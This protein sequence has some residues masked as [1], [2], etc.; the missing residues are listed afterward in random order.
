[1]ADWR[2]TE[3]LKPIDKANFG[4]VSESPGRNE[5]ERRGGLDKTVISGGRA[6]T[7]WAKAAW[8]VAGWLRRRLHSGG[9]IAAA[10]WQGD[11]EQLE[12][13]SSSRGEISGAG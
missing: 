6:F 8:V 4:L 11:A 2:E 5:S 9:V 10:R 1:M 12:K 3:G 13:P 7:V